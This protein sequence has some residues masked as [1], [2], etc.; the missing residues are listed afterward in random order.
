MKLTRLS[1]ISIAGCL[2]GL[3]A[4]FVVG[5]IMISQMSAKQAEMQSLMALGSRI[6]NFST[7]SDKLLISRA[8]PPAWQAYRTEA[9]ALKQTLVEKQDEYPDAQSAG[10]HMGE[11]IA[12]LERVYAEGNDRLFRDRITTTR[13][14]DHGAAIDSAMSEIVDQ[15]LSTINSNVNWLVGVFAVTTLIFGLGCMLSLTLFYRRIHGPLRSLIRTAARVEEGNSHIRAQPQGS[16]EFSEL[17]RTFNRMLD[18]QQKDQARLEE[19]VRLLDIAGETALFGGWWVDLRNDH[20]YWSDMVAEI[21]GLPHDYSP[22]VENGIS[23]YAPEHRQRIRECWS[24]CVD[25]GTP[26]DEELQII[27]TQGQRR[28]VRTIGVPVHDDLGKIVRVEGSFQDITLRHET[29]EKLQHSLKM[30]YALIDSLPA[31]IAVIDNEG[32]IF[33]TND[34]WRHFGIENAMGDECLGLGSNYLAVCRD[35]S[36]E[37]TEGA[38][39]SE[40]GLKALLKGERDTFALEYPCHSPTQER[41]FR[42]MARRLESDEGDAVPLGAVVMHIDITERKLAERQLEKLAYEDPLTGLLNRLG[43]TAAV[44]GHLQGQGWHAQ[45]LVVV[46][47]IKGQSNINDAHGYHIGDRLLNQIGQRLRERLDSSLVGCINGDAFVFFL[48]GIDSD[49]TE[50]QWLNALL[51]QPFMVEDTAIEVS[52]RF[53]FTFLGEKRRSAERLLHEAELALFETRS[54]GIRD[55]GQYSPRLDQ[56]IHERIELTGDLQQA[57]AENQLELHFQPKVNLQNGELIACEALMRWVHPERGMLSPGVFIP[58]AEQSQLIGPMGEWV[59]FEACR[60]LREWQDAN[61]EVVSVAV[62]VSMVQFELGGLVDQVRHAI[63]V[64]RI[65]PG[66][67]TLEITESVFA[68]QSEVL[69]SQMRELHDLGVRLSLDDFGTGYS[70]L[71]Y[72]QSYPFDEIKIDMGFVRKLLNDPYSQQIVTAV[73]RIGAV[74]GTET[75]AEGIESMEIRDMLLDMGCRVGQGYYYSMPLAAEDFQ[76]LLEK[77]SALPLVTVS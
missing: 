39:E 52:A 22:C 69:L 63:A 21:H 70:S 74:L 77:R 75:V 1:L 32:N 27:N 65:D 23:F 50:D 64:H 51:H 12:L 35:A 44:N 58:V 67:L 34:Q 11:I 38:S 55:W 14:A 68:H 8:S 25:A 18:Q 62:N 59:L 3:S 40:E 13:V 53:G 9:A 56:E 6:D 31:H 24:A 47:D 33:D 5:S 49:K 26:Y 29:S 72:L 10:H 30:R 42:L 15:Q 20:C 28:W 36:G 45:S 16:D 4:I 60:Q 7:A 46:M 43:F 57:L 61:L 73:L 2:T 19:H 71:L 66:N 17:A 37:N 54:R 41:W 48:H 76:W